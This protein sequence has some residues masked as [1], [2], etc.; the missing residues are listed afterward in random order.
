MKYFVY[1]LKSLTHNYYYVGLTNNLKRRIKQ[2]N[3]GKVKS[4]KHYQPFKLMLVKEFSDRISARDFEKFLKIRS[5]KEKMI[6][7]LN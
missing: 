1:L 6:A 3:Q 2:H 5:N 7:S 4:T